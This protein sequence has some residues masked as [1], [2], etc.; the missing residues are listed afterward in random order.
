MFATKYEV[1]WQ[2][3]WYKENQAIQK[4]KSQVQT[5]STKKERLP[6]A[7]I[8]KKCV[9]NHYVQYCKLS[10]LNAQRTQYITCIMNILK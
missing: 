8:Y 2:K 4:Q 7:N 9:A 1:K 3:I 5:C 10:P 6:I